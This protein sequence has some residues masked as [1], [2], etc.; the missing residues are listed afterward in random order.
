MQT[1]KSPYQ[2][3]KKRYVTEKAQVLGELAT[4]T[5]NKSVAKCDRPK[6]VFIVDTSANKAE[7]KQAIE[8]IYSKKKIT[9]K[10][11]NTINIH[12]KKRV[13]RGRK[14]FKSGFKKAIITLAPGNSID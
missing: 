5:S 1:H 10:S 7:I 9:V 11:V 8:E 2:I 3:I 14:G 12:P 6:Y 13:V 4:S